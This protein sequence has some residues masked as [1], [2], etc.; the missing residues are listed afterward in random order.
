MY[1]EVIDGYTAKLGADH[2][3]TVTAK[4]NLATLLD[5]QGQTQ[6]AKAM[7]LEVIDGYTAK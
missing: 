5:E 4:M 3:S 6:E 2:V 1:L 7:Y